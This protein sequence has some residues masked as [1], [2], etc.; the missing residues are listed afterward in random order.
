[1]VVIFKRRS[2]RGYENR[3]IEIVKEGKVF[4][5]EYIR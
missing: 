3:F 2:V 1:M 5:E 4:Y